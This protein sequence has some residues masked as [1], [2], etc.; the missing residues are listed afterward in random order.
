MALRGSSKQLLS[1]G[2]SF[3]SD[4]CHSWF[5]FFLSIL[6]Q[7]SSPLTQGCVCQH[8][9]WR[10]QQPSSP[11]EGHADP[12][13]KCY[14]GH[15]KPSSKAVRWGAAVRTTVKAPFCSM[16]TQQPSERERPSPPLLQ[17]QRQGGPLLV[18][19]GGT[20]AFPCAEGSGRGSEIQHWG[21]PESV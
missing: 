7:Q 6:W 21:R 1:W 10:K 13:A 16:C 9:R 18:L 5:S 12:W 2:I 19:A 3:T 20:C 4:V 17:L 14:S 15:T 11:V 8:W